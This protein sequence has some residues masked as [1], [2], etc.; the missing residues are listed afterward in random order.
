MSAAAERRLA[1]RLGVLQGWLTRLYRLD[2]C[3]EAKHFVMSPER[4]RSLLP[5]PS[6]RSGVV[7]LEE[8]D[9][10][11]LGVYLDPRDRCQLGALVEETSHLVCLA[12]HAEIGRSVSRLM[13]ELQ[14]EVDQYLVGRLAGRDGLAHFRGFRW[15]R[16]MDGTTRERYATAH[17]VAHRYC[18]WLSR[19]FPRRSDTPALLREL[20][21]FYRA[22][23]E[24]KLRAGV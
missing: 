18:R 12:W 1:R 17:R 13:L 22:P 23:S 21:A 11:W 24:E 8:A 7:A 4:A 6:P 14:G 16:W 15:A 9:T 10:L 3:F 2:L 5:L 19:R 20:R